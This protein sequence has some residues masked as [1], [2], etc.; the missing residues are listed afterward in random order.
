[1]R[2]VVEEIL[3]DDRRAMVCLHPAANVDVAV[4]RRLLRSP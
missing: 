4:I 1:M 2:R 3:L